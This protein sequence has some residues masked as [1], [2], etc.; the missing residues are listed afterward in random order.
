MY[1]KERG[2]LQMNIV[3]AVADISPRGND[4]V[5]FVV[6]NDNKTMKVISTRDKNSGVWKVHKYFNN[7]KLEITK[8]G[9]LQELMLEE[10]GSTFAGTRQEF[11]ESMY[12]RA[13]K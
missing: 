3:K 10:I 13:T 5:T 12:Q 9:K 1:T 11:I 6:E 7:A 2:E 4:R 8:A